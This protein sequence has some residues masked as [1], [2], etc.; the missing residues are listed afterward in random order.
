MKAYIVKLTFEGIEPVIWRRVILPADATFNRL[1]E[2]IQRVTNFQ[3]EWMDEPY[4]FFEIR[5]DDLLVTNTPVVL[6]E[7]KK[8]SNG[9]TAKQPS[10]IKIDTYLEKHGSLH[11][12]YDWGDEW[13]ITVELEEI[14]EDYFFGY[15]TL[16]AGEGTAPPEDVGGPPG[17]A[18]FLQ[19]YRDPSH[20]DYLTTYAWAE[21]QAYKSFDLDHINDMLKSMKYKKTEWARIDHDNYV[22]LSDKY[23]GSDK[24]DLNAIPNKKLYLDYI[25]A[26]TSL[27][28][29]VRF[30]KVMDIYNAQNKPEMTHKRMLQ[31]VNDPETVQLLEKKFVY[32]QHHQFL[33]ESMD[34][35]DEKLLAKRTAGKPFYVP[36]KT[37]LLHY[38]KDAYFKRTPQHK[39]LQNLLKKDG[40][41]SRQIEEELQDLVGELSLVNANTNLIFRNFASR[42]DLTNREQLQRY[43]QPVMEIANSTRIWEN[44]GHTPDELFQMEKHHLK[45][46][47]EPITV[48][49]GRNDPCPCGS[50]KKYKKCCG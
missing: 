41:T 14:V 40:L 25:A 6:E 50:G 26:C 2:L 19:V 16:L 48:K 37:E 23:R 35:N 13:R 5:V 45:P 39:K 36:N 47:P 33:H 22:V 10:R 3:S 31:L 21:E 4:H 30:D 44:R 43:L 27:Y 24:A 8:A 20:P 34:Y 7:T 32:M 9:L 18:A 12:L 15:P 38:V 11:Y 28:G 46:L 49:T 42:L 1:H 17:Y 29:M